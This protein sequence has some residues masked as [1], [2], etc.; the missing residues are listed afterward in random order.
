MVQIFNQ[1]N[2]FK[3]TIHM[4]FDWFKS[5]FIDSQDDEVDLTSFYNNVFIKIL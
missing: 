5:I 1:S 3:S 4:I 2:Y